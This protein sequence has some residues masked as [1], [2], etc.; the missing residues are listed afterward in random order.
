MKHKTVALLF[1]GK[2]NEHEVSCR[3]AATVLSALLESGYR[4]LCIG[5]T[6]KGDFLLYR[7]TAA[8]M[9]DAS[10]ESTPAISPVWFGPDGCIITDEGRA[11]HPDVVFP[12]LHGQNC[13][14]GRMQGFLDIWGVP[15]V[16]CGTAC[17]VLSM[18][19]ALTKRIAVFCDIPTLPWV[20]TRRAG[21][22]ENIL[23]S[24]N[25]P[26]FIK[27]V[28][29]GSSVG[30]ARADDMKTLS[31]ALDNAAAIDDAILAEP[32]FPGREIEVALLSTDQLIVSRPGEVE[33]NATFYDYDTKYKTDTARTYIPA[34]IPDAVSAAA[35]D[36]AARLFHALGG[37][38]LARVDFF[39]DGDTLYFNEINTMPGFT[40]ISMYP[41]LLA[42]SGIPLFDLVSR[43]VEGAD[44]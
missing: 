30:A 32:C 16:G 19:K 12:V 8:H 40:S 31:A 41:Q 42:D 43:L 20:E 7:G 13:E 15:Y 3:S 6:K 26:I 17:S 18:N 37:R 28:S 5:I 11:Y 14:D 38:H 4:V 35:R 24:L 22:E 34:R 9:Q 10:W 39:T 21:A 23:A 33:A 27:P 44:Q 29:S 2:S 25:F 36:Y 1:G